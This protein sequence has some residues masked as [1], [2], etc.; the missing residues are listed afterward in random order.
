[1][2]AKV[3]LDFLSCVKPQEYCFDTFCPYL[4]IREQKT[5][6]MAI[7]SLQ[8]SFALKRH[9]FEMNHLGMKDHIM[10]QSELLGTRL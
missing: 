4:Y 8:G 9:V 2:V 10:S 7:S 6:N 5:F 3:L 1:M